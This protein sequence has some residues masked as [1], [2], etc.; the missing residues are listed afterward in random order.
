MNTTEAVL[1]LRSELKQTQ[2]VFAKTIGVSFRSLCRYE[3]GFAPTTRVLKTLAE[4]A[5]ENKLTQ[6]QGYFNAV[7]DMQMVA[8]LKRL[9]AG[10]RSRIRVESEQLSRWGGIVEQVVCAYEMALR[11]T[12]KWED[13][14]RLL[15]SVA[16]ELYSVKDDLQGYVMGRDLE[17]VLLWR[18]MAAAT[19]AHSTPDGKLDLSKISIAPNS[20]VLEDGVTIRTTAPPVPPKKKKKPASAR[21]KKDAR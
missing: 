19:A 6:L 3:A 17:Q 5:K 8:R 11:E 10:G 18:E 4:V 21:R 20:K 13:A 14:R 9:T 16:G 12:T 2:P 1:E 7:R 15:R